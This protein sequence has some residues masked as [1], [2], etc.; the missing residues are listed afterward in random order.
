MPGRIDFLANP[1]RRGPKLRFQRVER[2]WA[3]TRD[4]R[5]A[6][7][8][9]MRLE[10]VCGFHSVRYSQMPASGVPTTEMAF[11]ASRS[12]R[13]RAAGERSA[14]NR[15]SRKIGVRARTISP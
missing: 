15:S 4:I 5:S 13:S 12:S 7:A 11:L 14:A 10:K 1:S 9:H 3:A 8:Q 6:A 2:F